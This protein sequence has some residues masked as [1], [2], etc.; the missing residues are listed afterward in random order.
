MAGGAPPILRPST[1]APF[2]IRSFR[3]QWPADLATS[4]AIEMEIIILGWYILTETGSV[5]LLTLYGSLQFLGTLFAPIFGMVGDRIGH[6]RLL[7]GMRAFYA[8]LSSI[9]MILAFT[10]HIHPAPVL[11]IAALFGAVRPSDVVMRNTLIG[12]TMP[13]E[14]LMGALGFSRSTQDMAK[15]FGALAG[16]TLVAFLGMAD[17]YI[18]IV[19]SYGLSVALTFGAGREADGPGPGMRAVKRTGPPVSPWRDLWTAAVYIWSTPYMLATLALACLVNL[20]AFPMMSGVLPYVAKEV[21]LL[22]QRGLGFMVSAMSIGS[23]TGSILIGRFGQHVMSGRMMIV[24]AAIWHIVLLLFGQ[25]GAP[26]LG[27]A[28]IFCAGV[29]QALVMVPMS[30]VLVRTTSPEVRGRVMGLRSLAV[31]TLPVGL[32][33]AGPLIQNFGYRATVILYCTLGLA[34]IAAIVLFWRRHLWPPESPANAR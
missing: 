26:L 3:F 31:Y 5:L 10:G 18:V 24:G 27:A 2:R 29:S 11:A 21:Y 13:S 19:A 22:D 7:C 17:A 30:L 8:V 14:L 4:L 1:L 12:A 28:V 9:V 20:T 15:I 16:A 23:L 34:L 6:R 25:V 32:L 33:I